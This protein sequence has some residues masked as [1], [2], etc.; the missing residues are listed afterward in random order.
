MSSTALG[1][2]VE[3]LRAA[4]GQFV[5]HVGEGHGGVGASILPVLRDPGKATNL[6][7]VL[8]TDNPDPI[9]KRQRERMAEVGLSAADLCPWNVYPW[10]HDSE[11]DGDL[12]VEHIARG[13]VV[14]REAIGLMHNLRG[15]L[16]QGEQARW[17]WAMVT[18]FAPD[19]REHGFE[20]VATCRPPGTRHK[21]TAVTAAN[22][23]EQLD[24][25]AKAVVVAP[26]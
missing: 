17:G 26:L 4:S 24:D 22:K 20:V 21:T 18:A 5:S 14:S 7:G 12:G 25:W 10:A 9:S 13:A 23:S 6:T 15:L 11:V 19:V 2:L 1:D 8:S 16:L 3:R